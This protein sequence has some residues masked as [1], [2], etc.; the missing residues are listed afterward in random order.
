MWVVKLV[1]KGES[2]LIG[3]LCKKHGIAASGY[4]V[5]VQ[6]KTTGID[7]YLVLFL[8]GEGSGKQ[9]FIADFKRSPRVT[10]MEEDKDFIL[11]QIKESS[12]AEP[13][14]KYNM[15]HVEPVMFYKDGSEVWTVASWNKKEVIEFADQMES[16]FQVKI[17]KIS[18]EPIS[19]ISILTV[20]P[21]ITAPQRRAMELA[22]E[23]GYY[24]NPRKIDLMALAKLMSVSYSTYQVHLRKAERKLL[25]FF[26][27][28]G[29]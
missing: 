17:L 29:K 16:L 23:H 27:H 18:N 6:V 14:Y 5:S 12:V 1:M 28:T 15:V 26:F 25:P 21:E 8:F 13:I 22:I 9:R 4:P 11:G 24:E 7:L 10:G 2:A 3:G 19:N 20:H